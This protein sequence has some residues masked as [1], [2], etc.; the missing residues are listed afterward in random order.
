[1]GSGNGLAYDASTVSFPNIMDSEKLKR[2]SLLGIHL[3]LQL[4]LSFRMG[5]F[6]Y[7]SCIPVLYYHCFLSLSLSSLY[8]S[9]NARI[10]TNN[11]RVGGNFQDLVTRSLCGIIGAVWGGLS[12]AAGNGN[13]YVVAVFAVIYMVP[14]LYRFTR[15]SH[16]RSGIVGRFS[17]PIQLQHNS[18]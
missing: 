15:S 3:R 6:R 14:F 9:K 10:W 12:Y 5:Y 13:P 18:L 7:F 4:V 17:H 11:C 16:P 1:V 8:S 2:R